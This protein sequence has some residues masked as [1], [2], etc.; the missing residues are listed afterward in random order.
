MSIFGQPRNFFWRINLSWWRIISQKSAA[1][2][3]SEWSCLNHLK[4]ENVF[5]QYVGRRN[6]LGWDDSDRPMDNAEGRHAA[7]VYIVS[8]AYWSVVISVHQLWSGGEQQNVS[9]WLEH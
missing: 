1:Y 2:V 9:H 8:L 6:L 5:F 4:A 3:A 7:N